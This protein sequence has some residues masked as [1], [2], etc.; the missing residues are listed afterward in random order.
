M[1][2]LY[3]ISDRKIIS[4]KSWPTRWQAE[5]YESWDN[6]KHCLLFPQYLW[7]RC[8]F[9]QTDFSLKHWVQACHLEYHWPYDQKI[10]FVFIK[11]CWKLNSIKHQKSE[12][13]WFRA[14]FLQVSAAK[15]TG[16][17]ILTCLALWIFKIRLTVPKL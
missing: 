11:G 6:G 17:S 3:I 9:F 15:S 16:N 12:K 8:I 10:F 13:P 14:R 7:T 1:D 5:K 2:T 4:W